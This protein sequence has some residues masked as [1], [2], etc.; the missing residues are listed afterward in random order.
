MPDVPK[1]PEWNW[2]FIGTIA[3]G[4]AALLQA[5]FHRRK[6]DPSEE[7][8]VG[9]DLL[10]EA[11]RR[12]TALEEQAPDASGRELTDLLDRAFSMEEKHRVLDGHMIHLKGVVENLAADMTTRQDLREAERR[13]EGRLVSKSDLEEFGQRLVRDLRQ[14]GPKPHNSQ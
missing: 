6:K 10:S 3:A 8:E 11:L 2:G 1:P 5:L 14:I 12:I 4:V 9:C 13:L 7:D